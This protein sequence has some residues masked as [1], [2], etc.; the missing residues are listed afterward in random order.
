MYTHKYT[1]YYRL[2]SC[3][4][5]V[6]LFLLRISDNVDILLISIEITDVLK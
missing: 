3:Y 1:L 4:T 5:A 2:Y 6:D